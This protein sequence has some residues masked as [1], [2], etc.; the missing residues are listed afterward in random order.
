MKLIIDIPEAVKHKV[1][2]YGLSLSPSDKEQ[3]I[4]AI[5]NGILSVLMKVIVIVLTPLNLLFTNLFPDV[6]N[7]ISTFATFV[8]TYIGGALSYFF[9]LLPP[10][11]R[12]LLVAFLTF[13][14]AYYGVYYTYVAIKKIFDVIQKVKL[15]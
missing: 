3:L 10:I 5:I 1:Y 6:S 2:A 4:K 9:S 13:V 15:W 11:F 7:M 12:G 14:I 8:N